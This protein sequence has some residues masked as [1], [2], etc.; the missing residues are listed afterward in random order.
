MRNDLK[1]LPLLALLAVTLTLTGCSKKDDDASN[2]N[3]GV[4][5]N[6]CVTKPSTTLWLTED[7]PLTRDRERVEAVLREREPDGFTITIKEAYRNATGVDASHFELIQEF[8]GLPLC[9]FHEKAFVVGGEVTVPPFV[10]YTAPSNL[11]DAS[12]GDA[13]AALALAAQSM[14]MPS[15][16]LRVRAAERCLQAVNGE[17]IPA[18]DITASINGVPYRV[19]GNASDVFLVEAQSLHMAAT[20]TVYKRNVNDGKTAALAVEVADDGSLNATNVRVVNTDGDVIGPKAVD[21]KLLP[22]AES[23]SFLEVSLFAHVQE[24]LKFDLQYRTLSTTDCMPIEIFAHAGKDDGP[25]YLPS[26]NQDTGHPRIVV[27]DSIPGTLLNLATDYDAVAHETNHHFVYQRLKSLSYEP[28]KIIHEGLADYFVF[29]HTGDT[30]LAESICPTNATSTLCVLPGQCLRSG[31]VSKSGMMFYNEKYMAETAY[32]R[33]S[34]AL[35]GLLIAIGNDP[36]VG[37]DNI[38][39]S[40]FAGI[41]FLKE[42]SEISDWLEALLQGDKVSFS[43]AHAC[44]IVAKAKAYGLTN[45]TAAIDCKT[46]QK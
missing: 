4:T 43:G 42:K 20:A 21:G 23:A 12:F 34:Q 10:A 8:G 46:Y 17:L 36:T 2:K 3:P 7:D 40:M 45:E 13:D 35:S 9:G 11:G 6:T 1:N 22:V 33:K 5:V 38:A 25:V 18:L 19:I 30:C 28:S 14:S 15:A 29:A 39:K 27:P 16:R 37:T 41:D 31:D 26:W 24:Q 44:T 32:H